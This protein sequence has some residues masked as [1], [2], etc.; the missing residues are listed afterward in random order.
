MRD[1][2]SGEVHRRLLLQELILRKDRRDNKKIDGLAGIVND[3]AF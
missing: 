1:N 2:G 3:G